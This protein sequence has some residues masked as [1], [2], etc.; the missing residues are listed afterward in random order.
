MSTLKMV[1]LSRR[2][3]SG[4]S[5]KRKKSQDPATDPTTN[6]TYMYTPIPVYTVA[7]YNA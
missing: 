6:P 2:G 3:R 7:I 5:G 4:V 1:A